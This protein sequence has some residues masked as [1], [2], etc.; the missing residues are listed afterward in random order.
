MVD[1]ASER[2]AT[3]RIAAMEV[4][5]LFMGSSKYIEYALEQD[6]YIQ[7]GLIV[8]IFLYQKFI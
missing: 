4:K 7:A 3:E 6:Y 8:N 5:N 1:A 2:T